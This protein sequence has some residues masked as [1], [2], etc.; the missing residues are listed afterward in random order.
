[1]KEENILAYPSTVT[2]VTNRNIHTKCSL[3]FMPSRKS[4]HSLRTSILLQCPGPIEARRFFKIQART[5]KARADWQLC[6]GVIH[7]KRC[8]WIACN[9]SHSWF[10]WANA[11]RKFCCEKRFA[12]LERYRV[13]GIKVCLLG[14][15]YFTKFDETVNQKRSPSLLGFIELGFFKFSVVTIPIQKR[16]VQPHYLHLH[17]PM[18][19]ICVQQL[20][21]MALRSEKFTWVATWVE[22]EKHAVLDHANFFFF[23]LQF[24]NVTFFCLCNQ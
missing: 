1:M 17:V 4:Y 24:Q 2:P 5:G 23:F 6:D 19:Y 14:P 10:F 11:E 12:V 22:F 13:C 20:L 8:L 9:I 7:T 15:E 21:S 3:C 18:N 16:I